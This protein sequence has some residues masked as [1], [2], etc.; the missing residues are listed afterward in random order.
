[1]IKTIENDR[2]NWFV[3]FILPPGKLLSLDPIIAGGSMLSLYRAFNLHDTDLRWE[4]LKR[5]LVT[6]P[7]NAMIDSFGD[8]DI[9]FDDTNPIHNNAHEHHWLVRKKE[10]QLGSKIKSLSP[11]PTYNEKTFIGGPLGLDGLCKS[12]GWANSF[13]SSTHR[14][15]HPVYGG[16]IQ[17]IKKPISSVEELL[18]SFDF[19]NCAVAWHNG[20]LYYDDRID[21]AFSNFELRINSQ[22]PFE[23]TSIAMRV[24]GA[25][26]AYKY[27]DRYSIN[28]GPKL[29]DYIFKLYVD[30]KNINY[31]EYG[32]KIIELETIYGKKISSINTLKT[33][34][35]HFH[36]LFKKF[37]DMKYFKK[38]YALYLVD[39]AEKF[40]GLKELIG[41]PDSKINSRYTKT[42]VTT[43]VI[44]PCGSKLNIPF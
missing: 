35:T 23:R 28:F 20:V 34:V 9:W 3:E 12:T 25:L 1:V 41:E 42:P 36:S 13:R 10:D 22:E 18:S 8:I 32:N 2:I 15:I 19:I 30:T 40:N 14:K 11:G 24:F 43:G 21:D 27:S 4:T 17:F 33:M 6:T 5:S 37:S 31:E 29:T 26:R 44:M 39:Y 16:E 7:K 38:E